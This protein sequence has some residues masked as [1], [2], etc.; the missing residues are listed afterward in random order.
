[1]GAT[2]IGAVVVTGGATTEDAAIGAAVIGAKETGATGI[3]AAATGAGVTGA[4]DIG[5]DVTG[6]SLETVKAF[7]KFHMCEMKMNESMVSFCW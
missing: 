3:G 7:Y 6:V 5:A 4:V 1:M 2:E